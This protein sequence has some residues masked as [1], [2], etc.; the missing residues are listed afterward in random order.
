MTCVAILWF[1]LR[2]W[3]RDTQ[4]Q[5][6]Q[7]EE[8]LWRDDAAQLCHDRTEPNQVTVE[9]VWDVECRDCPL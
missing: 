2:M 6:F 4:N 3:D 5:I 8:K 1:F 7:T 9:K